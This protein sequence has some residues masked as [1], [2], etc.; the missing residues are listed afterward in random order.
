ME[1]MK[2]L[3]EWYSRLASV[4]S[5]RGIR[6]TLGIHRDYMSYSLN[7]LKWGNIGS[8]IGDYYRGY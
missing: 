2:V 5:K 3:P 1:R 7:S 4:D 8:Y 6:W